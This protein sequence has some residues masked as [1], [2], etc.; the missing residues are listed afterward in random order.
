MV[1]KIF[2][3][4]YKP[5]EPYDVLHIHLRVPKRPILLPAATREHLRGAVRETLL[6]WR[7]VLDACIEKTEKPTRTATKVRVE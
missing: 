1:Q 7:S 2:E 5:E 4:E 3:V 6:A